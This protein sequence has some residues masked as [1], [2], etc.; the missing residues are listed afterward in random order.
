MAELAALPMDKQ[1][2][3]I[4]MNCTAGIHRVIVTGLVAHSMFIKYP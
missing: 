4:M 2:W 1:K 3:V